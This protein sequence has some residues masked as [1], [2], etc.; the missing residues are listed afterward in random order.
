M[1][2]IHTTQAK[3]YCYNRMIDV[4]PVFYLFFLYIF[5]FEY[6]HI[7]ADALKP[8][9]PWYTV[10]LVFDTQVRDKS[11]LKNDCFEINL[12]Y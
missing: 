2:T 5:F 9:T 3:K 10:I 8:Y 11:I 7:Q 4:I 1:Y 6:S 12:N